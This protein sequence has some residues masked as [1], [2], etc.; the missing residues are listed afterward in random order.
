M[1]PWIGEFHLVPDMNETMTQQNE[2]TSSLTP[3]N[4]EELNKIQ[5][6]GRHYKKLPIQ[7]WDFNLQN[8]LDYFQGNIVKYVTRWKDKGWL[9]DLH[10]AKHYLDKYILEMEEKHKGTRQRD[11]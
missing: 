6:G 5:V 3:T 2:S 9:E 11:L 1:I 4:L 8:D 10:K 7:V